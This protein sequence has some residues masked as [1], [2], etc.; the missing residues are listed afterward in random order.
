VH[1]LDD[2][3]QERLADDV[4]AAIVAAPAADARIDG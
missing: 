2:A 3:D 4:A 1:E